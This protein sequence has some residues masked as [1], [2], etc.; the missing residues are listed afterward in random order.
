[1]KLFL[2]IVILSAT[3]FGCTQKEEYAQY[4]IT[5]N[6]KTIIESEYTHVTKKF[7]DWVPEDTNALHEYQIKRYDTVGNLLERELHIVSSQ[8]L[9]TGLMKISFNGKKIIR[10]EI[11]DEKGAIIDTFN[12]NYLSEDTY[13]EIIYNATEN[14]YNKTL[15]KID[16]RRRPISYVETKEIQNKKTTTVIQQFNYSGDTTLITYTDK[17]TG[18]V[19][20]LKYIAVKKDKLGNPLTIITVP[21][22]ST[23]NKPVSIIIRKYEYYH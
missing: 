21:G 4:G 14:A 16:N 8:D 15:V 3:I 19:T 23:D 22:N 1:M 12:Y 9:L 10:T 20:V 6:V 17:L 2:P 18:N 13:T 7:G 5:G 11:Y